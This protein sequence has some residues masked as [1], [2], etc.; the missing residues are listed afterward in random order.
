M[1]LYVCAVSDDPGRRDGICRPIGD[2][3]TAGAELNFVFSLSMLGAIEEIDANLRR[4]VDGFAVKRATSRGQRRCCLMLRRR[5]RL[6]S[7]IP[8]IHPGA[9]Y[10]AFPRKRMLRCGPRMELGAGMQQAQTAE[11][12]ARA[13]DTT[14]GRRF[15]QGQPNAAEGHDAER[16]LGF[17]SFADPHVREDAGG[18]GSADHPR[19][20]VRPMNARAQS[21]AWFRLRR[22]MDTRAVPSEKGW[23]AAVEL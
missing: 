14:R 20:P 4:L 5:V 17:F 15:R 21:P 11:D 12:A 9:V 23:T 13:R 7:P 8:H 22:V 6:Q 2:R 3:P 1:L 18:C 16:P 19:L 10:S